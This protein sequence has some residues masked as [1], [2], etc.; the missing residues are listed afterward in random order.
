MTSLIDAI[1]GIYQ[2]DKRGTCAKTR[3]G[4]GASFKTS[5][6]VAITISRGG[7]FLVLR[8]LGDVSPPSADRITSNPAVSNPTTTNPTTT[9]PSGALG[10]RIVCYWG[11]VEA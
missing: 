5:T 10:C 2:N 8:S 11:L 4:P 9:N 3:Q 1:P 7:L 6:F